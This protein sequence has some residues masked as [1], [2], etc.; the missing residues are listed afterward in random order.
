ML[1]YT[2]ASSPKARA[3]V[4]PCPQDHYTPGFNQQSNGSYVHDN[5]GNL[6]YDPHKKLT[7][8]YNYLNL[9]YKIIGA[10]NDELHMLYSA[11]GTLL[12]RKYIQNSA[13]KHKIDY[14]A[15]KEYLNDTLEYVHH[16]QGR[17]IK[18]N[19]TWQY[20]YSVKDHLGNVRATFCDL[21]GNGIISNN[22]RRSRLDYYTFGMEHYNNFTS[23]EYS[24][25]KNNYKYNGKEVLEE[26]N[27]G[28]QNY[29]MRMY[30][31]VIGRFTTKDRFAEKYATMSP[32]QYG[33][34]NP[35]KYVD[36]NGDSIKIGDLNY[37]PGMKTSDKYSE[38][39]NNVIESLNFI[40]NNGGKK[41]IKKL[42][43]SINNYFILES[44]KT[45]EYNFEPN[46]TEGGTIR[47]NDKEVYEFGEGNVQSAVV[48]LAHE[49]DH[50][51]KN[52]DFLRKAQKSGN[53]DK[54]IDFHTL[55]PETKAKEEKRAT[56]GL[57][58]KIAIKLGQY[59]RKKYD[60]DLTEIYLSNGPFSTKKN[61]I[62]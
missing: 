3:D 62:K 13:V 14:I 39:I 27:I 52:E 45:G 60:D 34:N 15:D 54:L 19:A 20:E 29:G 37:V 35:V 25:S 18:H 41:E 2:F 32:Y 5:S 26:M 42:S 58:R 24:I 30:D 38:Y 55:D 33:A 47:F 40:F 61:S 8:Q 9:P 21:N 51:S 36:V 28:L 12:Q 4:G 46:S 11:D 50:A 7:Y 23:T 16:G 57:E 17:L 56:Y 10:E 31:N 44:N 53:F 48:T 6:T 1:C 43:N 59:V 22:E 49:I